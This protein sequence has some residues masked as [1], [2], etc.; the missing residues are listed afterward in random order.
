MAISLSASIILIVIVNSNFL[1]QTYKAAIKG[2]TFFRFRKQRDSVLVVMTIEITMEMCIPKVSLINC[3]QCPVSNNGF[4]SFCMVSFINC[5]ASK[6]SVV[7]LFIRN[8][9]F[10]RS[11]SVSVKQ[12]I[13]NLVSSCIVI[14]IDNLHVEIW[15]GIQFLTQ[16]NKEEV[17]GY[18]HLRF[19]ITIVVY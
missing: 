10:Q 13:R 7:F 11:P 18:P 3:K 6:S 19:S 2:H 1:K 16:V 8:W 12:I 15:K 17:P 14:H 4:S 5:L 9:E